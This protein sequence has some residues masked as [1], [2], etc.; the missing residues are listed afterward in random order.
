M[1]WPW[2]RPWT[3]PLMKAGETATYTLTVT[4]NGPAQSAAGQITDPLP[5]GLSFV[6]SADGCV[7]NAGTVT[8]CS[9]GPGQWR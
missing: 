7:D 2:S 1:T 8:C 9:G 4:N 3:K 6:A 5:A